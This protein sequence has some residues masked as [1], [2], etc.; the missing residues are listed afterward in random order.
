M[1]TPRRSNSNS[2]LN[3]GPSRTL[4]QQLLEEINGAPAAQT[5]HTACPSVSSA[6]TYSRASSQDPSPSIWV[7]GSSLAQDVRDKLRAADEAH[8]QK[9]A[10]IAVDG[11]P[12]SK[13]STLYLDMPRLDIMDTAPR[14]E[15]GRGCFSA[16]QQTPD[17]VSHPHEYIQHMLKGSPLSPEMQGSHN[18]SFH[19][20]TL[21]P[22]H[23]IPPPLSPLIFSDVYFDDSSSMSAQTDTTISP[24]DAPT[25]AATVYTAEDLQTPTGDDSKKQILRLLSTCT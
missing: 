7:R 4:L 13:T 21:P 22:G 25:S 3:T 18:N 16:F 10:A 6:S 9:L 20:Q 8:R 19:P 12:D 2:A 15:F 23:A 17:P 1:D 5:A 24:T 14:D 11:A